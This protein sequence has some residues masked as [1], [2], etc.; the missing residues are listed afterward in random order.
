GLPHPH[1]RDGRSGDLNGARAYPKPRRARRYP[2]RCPR[3]TVSGQGWPRPSGMDAFRVSREGT[4]AGSV[5]PDPDRRGFFLDVA[6]GPRRRRHRH[7]QLDLEAAVRA[8]PCGRL[9]AVQLHDPGGDREPDA[10]TVRPVVA[11][12]VDA[13]ERL[14]D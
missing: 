4:Y 3:G 9:A 12:R 10:L 14:E 6:F 1:R 11:A 5:S 7:D 2:H 13:I 8:I